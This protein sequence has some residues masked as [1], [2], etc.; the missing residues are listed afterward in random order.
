MPRKPKKRKPKELEYDIYEIELEDWEVDYNYGIN[1][2]PKDII[3][4]DYWEHSELLLS[5]KILSSALKNA[6]QAKIK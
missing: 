5:G 6:A 2:V 3:L 1:K 4:G